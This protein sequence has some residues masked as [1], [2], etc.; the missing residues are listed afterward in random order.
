[1]SFFASATTETIRAPS[2]GL[3]STISSSFKRTIKALKAR[4]TK[5]PD[6]LTFAEA[7]AS[8]HRNE[9]LKAAKS[10]IEG[11]ESKRTWIEVL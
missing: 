6:T 2:Y 9:W 4:A 7:M 10:E 5:D 11:L 1:M 8:P 3:L